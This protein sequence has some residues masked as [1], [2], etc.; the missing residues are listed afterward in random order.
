[1]ASLLES[2]CLL[3]VGKIQLHREVLYGHQTDVSNP[4]LWERKEDPAVN[5]ENAGEVRLKFVSSCA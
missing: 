5:A 1:M 3:I 2:N 4:V